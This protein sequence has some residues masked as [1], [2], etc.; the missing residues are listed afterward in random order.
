MWFEAS[1]IRVSCST[2][3]IA[4]ILAGPSFSAE[5]EPA[6]STTRTITIPARNG[7]VQSKDIIASLEQLTDIDT[8]N[9]AQAIPSGQLR[10][11]SGGSR[12]M[13]LSANLALYPAIRLSVNTDTDGG[14][15]LVV[16]VDQSRVEARRRRIKSRFRR[17]LSR[18]SPISEP[19][20]TWINDVAKLKDD[21]L[22]VLVVHGL[23]S[24]SNAQRQW[25]NMLVKDR[26]HCGT[27][28]YPNDQSIAKS[29]EALSQAL[30]DAKETNPTQRIALLTHSMGGLVAREAIENE[31]LDPQNVTHLVMVSPPNQGSQL[32]FLS[33]GMDLWEHVLSAKAQRDVSFMISATQDGLNE[34]TK[35]LRP[36]SPF[37]ARL[38]SRPR[39]PD[40]T[41]KIVMGNRAFLNSARLDLIRGILSSS[42]ASTPRGQAIG[43]ASIDTMLEF[44][45]LVDGKG[46][47]AV[48]VERAKLPGVDNFSVARFS[49]R[50][51][52]DIPKGSEE[53]RA[54][55]EIIQFLRRQDQES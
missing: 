51:I 4:T 6:V 7:L 55:R 30:S 26:F 15:A 5:A 41:Y 3:I 19:K 44:D 34:A 28:A 18:T 9:L 45:E 39:N 36:T 49:H 10:L 23:N 31:R 25:I 11:N 14:Q 37:L 48:A 53:R 21:T 40:V 35:D 47:G 13:L 1:R 27:F 33:H 42:L 38:N 2:L 17:R 50:S 12:W 24:T 54:L 46:D 16:A 29:A 52:L 8:S 43:E 20:L 22:S 32:A